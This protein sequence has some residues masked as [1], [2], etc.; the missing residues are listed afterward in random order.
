MG[1]G[2]LGSDVAY[3]AAVCDLDSFGYL[4]IVN[5]KNVL[6]P[7]MSRISWKRRPISFLNAL[8][9]FG[10]SGPLI[11][12]LYSWGFPVS[13]NITTFI[14]PTWIFTYDVVLLVCAQSSPIFWTEYV[15]TS[16]LGG[17]IGW[18]VAMWLDIR[19]WPCILLALVLYLCTIGMLHDLLLYGCVS[20]ECASVS[21]GMKWGFV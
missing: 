14:W 19:P 2:L 10:L 18:N 21:S 15:D 17:F 1:F 20:G 8:V 4:I 16:V 3:Y 13:G 12:C 5:K 7:S 9:Y 6:V 11:R